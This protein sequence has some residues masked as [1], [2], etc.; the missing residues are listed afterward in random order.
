MVKKC[1]VV[2]IKMSTLKIQVHIFDLILHQRWMLLCSSK[3]QVS[4]YQTTQCNNQEHH[5]VNIAIVQCPLVDL[6]CQLQYIVGWFQILLLFL[7]F[8]MCY[9]RSMRGF[10][11]CYIFRAQLLSYSLGVFKQ[12]G[13]LLAQMAN[14]SQSQNCFIIFLCSKKSILCP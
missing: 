2:F 8:K 13:N 11:F 7:Q 6:I 4:T 9:P 14:L 1:N 5:S 12:A 10:H 3:K